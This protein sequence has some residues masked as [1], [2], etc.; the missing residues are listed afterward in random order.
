MPFGGQN[1]CPF[2][3]NYLPGIVPAAGPMANTLADLRLFMDVLSGQSPWK[4]DGTALDIPWRS[5]DQQATNNNKLVIGIA[6]EDEEFQLHPP[7]KRTLDDAARK[8]EAAGHTV[9]R[10]PAD[11]ARSMAL[12][13]RLAFSFYGLEGHPT[14]EE[15]EAQFGEPLVKSLA[16]GVHPFAKTP[17]PLSPAWSEAK[18][19]AEW[20]RLRGQYCDGW[21][22][23]WLENGLDV[24]VAPGAVSTA[25][26]HDAFGVPVYT[27]A[28]NVA[29]VSQDP[30]LI[31]RSDC[32]QH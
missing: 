23:A 11:P 21:R 19:V 20:H 8:L 16:A 2:P 15:M 27:A 12:G 3:R 22:R 28:W 17:P 9:V 32:G 10:L 6:P 13:G 18:R 25:V 26:A 5:L 7:V 29:N 1:A 24:V 14:N 4:Y 30:H 31:P